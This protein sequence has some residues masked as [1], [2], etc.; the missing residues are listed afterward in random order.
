[1]MFGRGVNTT[2][3]TVNDTCGIGLPF[4][5]VFAFCD[6]PAASCHFL[7][8]G[9]FWIIDDSWIVFASG[10]NY[11]CWFMWH[12]LLIFGQQTLELSKRTISKH[13]HIPFCSI[14]LS[15]LLP[16]LEGRL[17][18]RVKHLRILFKVGFEKSKSTTLYQTYKILHPP[19]LLNHVE[20][21]CILISCRLTLLCP[22]LKLWIDPGFQDFLVFYI[23]LRIKRGL[24][25]GAF[26]LLGKKF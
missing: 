15:F 23:Q 26:L 11:C 18:G 21:N 2:Q 1:M 6:I 13:V 9:S 19:C 17:E 5:L 3:H 10:L 14:K 22:C 25:K 4:C 20:P 16:L 24:I 7:R 8:M 12:E